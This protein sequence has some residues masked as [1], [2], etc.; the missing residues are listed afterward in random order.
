MV[1]P[2][3][4]GSWFLQAMKSGRRRFALGNYRLDYGRIWIQTREPGQS[5]VE[6]FSPILYKV[7]NDV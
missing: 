6:L 4:G 3:N 7:E 2:R 5:L 1:G